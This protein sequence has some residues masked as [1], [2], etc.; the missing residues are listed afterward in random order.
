M[1]IFLTAESRQGKKLKTSQAKFTT[2][3]PPRL[4][5]EPHIGLSVTSESL[6]VMWMP[7]V[8]RVTLC[9]FPIMP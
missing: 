8:T 7:S 9:L 1:C 3:H 6:E 5:D 2:H 4:T